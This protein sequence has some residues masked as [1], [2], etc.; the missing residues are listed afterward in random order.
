M[1]IGNS[2]KLN[3]IVDERYYNIRTLF[4]W[5]VLSILLYSCTGNKSYDN[6]LTKADSIMNIDD[7]SA[8]I[9][10]LMLDDIKPELSEF[11]K[12]QK[13]RYELAL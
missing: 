9:A 2:F 11:T 3:F 10:I 7:D 1:I 4:T 5:V 8:K 12:S 13:M 6:L